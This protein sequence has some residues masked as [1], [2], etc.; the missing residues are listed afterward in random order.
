VG[1]ISYVCA[2]CSQHFTRKTSGKRHNFNIHSGGAEIVPLIEY[3]VGRISGK[4]LASHPFWFRQ[5]KETSTKYQSA[6]AADSTRGMLKLGL[7]NGVRNT[8]DNRILGNASFEW[9]VPFSNYETRVCDSED[10]STLK[11]RFRLNLLFP[12]FLPP[13]T[14]RGLQELENLLLKFSDYNINPSQVMQY[15][16]DQCAKRD[17]KF[18]IDKLNQLRHMNA[19]QK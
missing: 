8:T 19:L 16:I 18:L 17:Y 14:M 9:R 5:Q 4:Y 6:T 3:L 1:R 2:E 7:E 15:A 11:K 13:D 10:Y 12:D